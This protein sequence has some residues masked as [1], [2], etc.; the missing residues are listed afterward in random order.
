MRFGKTLQESIYPPWKDKYIDYAKLK[1]M[2]REDKPE[3]DD[4]PWTEEDESRFCDEI[5][6]VQLEKVAQFQEEQ[7]ERLRQRV[8][9]AFDQLRELPGTEQGTSPKSNITTQRLKELESELDD[10]TNEVK[11]LRKYSNLN[12]TGFLKIVKKHDRKRGNRYKIRPMMQVS[13]SKRPF[14]SEQGYSPLLN[15]LSLMYFAIRQHLEATGEQA[16]N[17]IDVL[18][19]HTETTAVNGERYTAHKFWVHPDNLLEVKTYIMRQLPA[20]VYSERSAR[21]L[22]GNEDPT[23]TS[24]YFD[25]SRFELYNKKVESEAEASSVRLRWYGQLSAKPDIFMEQKTV[26]E[27]GSSEERRFVIKEKYI[28]PFL[29]GEYKMEKSVQKMERQGQSAEEV[30]E[31]RSTAD[32]IQEFVRSNKLEPVVRANYVRTAFQNPGDDRVRISIDTNIAFIRE[33]TLDRD[34]PCRDPNEWHRTDIDDSNMTYPFKNINQ[35]EVSRFPYAVLEIKLKEDAT[36][37]RA[38]WI[39]DLMSSHLV[40]PSPRFSKFVHGVASLFEDYVNRLPFW[41]A[42]LDIDIRKDPQ[43]AFEEEEQRRASRAENEQVVG[44]FL[45]TRLGSMSY[46]PSKSSPVGRSYLA[47]RVAAENAGGSAATPAGPRPTPGPEN[48]ETAGSGAAE[49]QRRDYGTLSSIFPGF[50]LSKYSKAKRARE[51]MEATPLPDGVVEPTEWIKN[52]GPLQIEPK[53]W[54][55]NE[56][57]FLKWQHI[58]VLLGG[59]AVSLYTAGAATAGESK[60]VELMGIGFILIAIFAGAWG[61]YMLHVRRNMIRQRSG[62]DFDNMVGPMVISAALMLALILNFVFA[63][64]KT[65]TSLSQRRGGGFFSLFRARSTASKAGKLLKLGDR[66]RR[67]SSRRRDSGAPPQGDERDHPSD[68]RRS[69]RRDPSGGKE[70]NESSFK[71]KEG[72][73][74]YDSGPLTEWPPEGVSID[75][76]L[77]L[78]PA[79][80]LI[81]K[82]VP[83]FKGHKRPIPHASDNYY[84]LFATAAGNRGDETDA[85]DRHDAMIQLMSLTLANPGGGSGSH[86]NAAT[87]PWETLEQPSMAFCFG[88]R[89]GT[90]TLNHWVSM[91]SVIPPAIALRD[92]GVAPREID[93][94]GIFERLKQLERGLEDDDEE[95]MYRNLYKRLLRDPDRGRNPHKTLDKQIMDLIMVLSRAEWI[96]FTIPRNQVVTKFIFDTGDTNSKTYLKF[97]HQ[98]LLSV[99]LDMRINSRHHVAEAKEKLLSQIPP[100]LQWD[101]ALAR[102]WRENVRVE[103]FGKTPDQTHLRFKLK[104]RQVNMMRRFAKIMKWPNL[105]ATLDNIRQGDTDNTLDLVS[106]DTMAFFSG[107]VL[108][109]GTFPFLI[110]NTLID[111]DP[112]RATDDLAL[113]THIHPHC[114]F[115]YRNSYTYWTATSIVGKVL[116]PTCRSLAG[117]VG[118]ARPTVDLGRSQ[119]ARIRSRTPPALMTETEKRLTPEDVRSMSERSDPL[120]PPAEVFPVKEYALVTADMEEDSGYHLAD[121]VRIELLNLKPCAD[122]ATEPGPRWFDAVLQFAIDGVSWPLRL[123]FDVSFINAWPCSDGPHPL[124]FDYAH[125]RVKADELVNVRN[126]NGV[127]GGHPHDR[128]ARS[129]SPKVPTPGIGGSSSASSGSGGGGA[130]KKAAAAVGSDDA[131]E[132]DE[133]KVLVVEAFGVPDNEVLARA[134]CSHWGL[135]AVVADIG[136]TCMACAIREAYAA[137]LTVVILVD[138]GQEAERDD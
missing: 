25:N 65:S 26:H 88:R 34:R 9:A 10:I 55:A 122:R 97:F 11:E 28:K 68:R 137:T 40:H 116:A 127:Y 45:G 101:L 81:C 92:P 103:E 84:A 138:D 115:Q 120:G 136:K 129:L 17:P 20:L 63:V 12:Y 27:N 59:L 64:R 72:G 33:D 23:I 102:R 48:G 3:D 112:D 47:E 61:Y 117:W 119:I 7:V 30:D 71:G 90:I 57:T 123:A 109:G 67:R 126:W 87:Y 82:G 107:L 54:L 76:E 130:D 18:G 16:P 62:K 134:W 74:R 58:C 46:K 104:R 53:V 70:N 22:E 91:A 36:R 69:S 24:L 42:D 114:G 77:K 41:L 86:Q 44:S 110:M 125:A 15:K 85:A 133:E 121:I 21:E 4:E 13:L 100:T 32:A 78:G 37:K 49:E 93:L 51:R 113:L 39:E 98:L 99:E 66:R 1:S 52:S 118:P 75:G 31:F 14:N 5:F 83:A 50:S 8:D 106:S 35:S 6:N 94:E 19:T 95:R 60:L 2:L 56:R 38:S 73:D 29:D 89:P 80:Q 128:N 43:V 79:M 105:S 132:R 108:P 135:S 131:S 111:M 124:F 96:D